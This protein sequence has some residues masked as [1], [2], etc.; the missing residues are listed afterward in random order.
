MII[1]LMLIS[2][3]YLEDG[4]QDFFEIGNLVT[5]RD[6]GFAGDYVEAV[7]L[8]LQA[9]KADDCVIATN[10]THSLRE[11]IEK[12]AKIID[13]DIHW[14]GKGIDEIGINQKDGRVLVKINHVYYG[15]AEVDL[16]LG[17]YSKA[18]KN[19]GWEPNMKFDDLINH[20][21]EG[22]LKNC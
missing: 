6:W 5:K 18:K 9:D 4:R 21:T 14:Q 11:F 8:M 1:T 7:R 19:L 12:A 13:I 22:D 2:T 20:M 15:P 16:L 17:D 10:K 3:M